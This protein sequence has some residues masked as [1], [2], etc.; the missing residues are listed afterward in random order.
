MLRQLPLRDDAAGVSCGFSRSGFTYVELIV[1]LAVGAIVLGAGVIAFSAITTNHPLRLRAEPIP[2]TAAVNINFYD[3][4]SNTVSVPYAPSVGA[5]AQAEVMREMFSEDLR[6]SVGI[7]VLSRPGVNSI[8][9]RNLPLPSNVDP[10]T[11]TNAAAFSALLVNQSEYVVNSSNAI[12]GPSTTT[13]VLDASVMSNTLTVRCLYETDFIPI[14]SPKGVFASVR[15]YVN[16]TLTHYY[17]VFYPGQTNTFSP[18]GYFYPRGTTVGSTTINRPFYL[19]WWPDP[20]AQEMP[21]PPSTLDTRS[22]YTNT[23]GSSSFF[24]V[25]PMFPHL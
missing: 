8:R 24:F 13:Y 6:S 18:L 23:F 17:H 2:I 3:I 16:F 10:R 25:A 15:R 4:S 19:L 9:L 12:R 22:S 20:M 7:Y 21:A 1:G 5:S 11:L 14:A